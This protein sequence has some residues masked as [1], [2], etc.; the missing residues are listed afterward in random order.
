VGYAD[1]RLGE[2]GILGISSSESV[3]AFFTKSSIIERVKHLCASL[4]LLP[5]NSLLTMKQL[6]LIMAKICINMG[7]QF[8]WK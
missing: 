5:Q 1:R 3:D 6:F 4:L 2:L 7:T 8:L